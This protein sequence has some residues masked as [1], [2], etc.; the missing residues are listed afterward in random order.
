MMLSLIPSATGV[1]TS[2]KVAQ[3][4][5]GGDGNWAGI[6]T[7]LATVLDFSTNT[8]MKMKVYSPVTGRALFK[9][10]EVGNPE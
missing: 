5:K 7:T 4:V 3:Y 2:A 6:E 9:V 8:T 10:E 1:N